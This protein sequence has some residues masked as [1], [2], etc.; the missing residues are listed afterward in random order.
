MTNVELRKLLSEMS[1]EEKI[2]ELSQMPGEYYR[3]VL[4]ATGE[5]KTLKFSETTVRNAGSAINVQDPDFI[6]EVQK[7]HIKNHPHGIPMLFMLDIIH[8]Y[9]TTFPIPLAQACSFEPE[10]VKELAAATA[11]ESAVS[12]IHVTFSPMVDLSRDPRW[13]R[14]MEGSGEDPYLNS[15]MAKAAV[16]GYQG[17]DLTKD[18]TISACVK[19][20]TG[21][22]AVDGGR[23]YASVDIS[24]RNLRQYHLPSYKAGC[25]AG[26]GMLMSSFNTIG[27]VPST[28]NRHILREILRDEWGY[29]GAVITDYGSLGGMR[30]HGISNDSAEL[31]KLGIEAS[32]DIEM[33]IGQY[34]YSL[35]GLVERGEVSM[36]LVDE[37]VYRVLN[38][39]NRLGLFENPYRFADSEKAKEI[40]RSPE[41]LELARR[42]IAKTSVL[43]K[44]DDNIL[45]LKPTEKIAF[46]GPFL[47]EHDFRG[48]WGGKYYKDTAPIEEIQKRYPD[49]PFTY[50]K[51]CHMIGAEQPEIKFHHFD[52]FERDPIARREKIAEAAKIAAEADKVVLWLG[53]HPGTGGELNSKVFIEIPR[54]QQELFG[55]VAE[56]N[57]NTAV[58]LFNHR[59][60]D[61][62]EI[63]EKSK[64]IL[65][66]WFPGTMAAAGITDV[67]FGDSAPTGR[68]TMS[69]PYSVGQCPIYYNMLPTDHPV[70]SSPHFVTGYI[71]CPLEPLYSFGEGLTYTEFEYGEVALS[72]SEIGEGESLTASV[73][74]K[75]IGDRDGTE[76]V[77]LYIRDPFASVSRPVKELKGFKRVDIKAGETK[78]VEF[79]I[80]PEMCKFYNVELEYVWEVGEIR[81]FIGHDSRVKEY[82]SFNLK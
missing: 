17:D 4:N 14:V 49:S 7:E 21:Y 15:V 62:R 23:E 36:E 42:S 9:H 6:I 10:L 8:G 63:T 80:T 48:G 22:G 77:Q 2:G 19:H 56:A 59:P 50:V 16:E 82:K 39:K 11:K 69:F 3:E 31:A 65:A 40:L 51:G 27:G 60:L 5:N 37:A 64:A 25:D 20:F 66:V 32:V 47:Y 74:V 72:R 34:D 68:L 43:L 41:I 1:L 46:I 18:G 30:S 24:E 26:S 38:L 29:E 12:G 44:N 67:I 52:Q 58:V 78:T 33:C 54:I 35:A 53:E 81:V 71:D 79:E 13:G 57:P 61:I 28:G 73:T 45:P 76:T 55:A 70:G 75:N